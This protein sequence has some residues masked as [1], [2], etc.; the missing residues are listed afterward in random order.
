[1]I[2]SSGYNIAGP[3][4]EEALLVHHAVQ[5]CCVV[6]IPDPDRGQLV[7]AF[8]V[9]RE[10]VA[11]SQALATELQDFAKRQIA[12]YKYP[13]A[14]EFVDRLPRSGTGKV[15]RFLLRQQGREGQCASR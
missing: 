3:E 6:G 5:E 10:G 7:K 12:P 11:G 14:I 4:V 13:R 15:Q 2:V 8:I 1:M 9:L